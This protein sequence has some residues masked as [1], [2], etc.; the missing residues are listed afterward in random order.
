M[1]KVPSYELEGIN[2]FNF[3]NW[4]WNEDTIIE[5]ITKMLSCGEIYGLR[6]KSIAIKN[7]EEKDASEIKRTKKTAEKESPVN[8][9][10]LYRGLAS[11]NIFLFFKYH[12]P[13]K[14]RLKGAVTPRMPAIKTT[15][16]HLFSG[17]LSSLPPVYFSLISEVD[18]GA[19]VSNTSWQNGHS[20]V[21]RSITS[22]QTGQFLTEAPQNKSLLTGLSITDDSFGK[23]EQPGV[24]Q[25][26]ISSQHST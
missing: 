10:M 11:F 4:E 14:S 17:F 19:A 18:N 16:A 20:R 25:P 22:L 1:I 3:R 24:P 6:I 13:P 9:R 7:K 15:T 2:V 12:I 26:P 8:A 5:N 21:F 23:F